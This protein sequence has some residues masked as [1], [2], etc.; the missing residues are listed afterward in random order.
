MQITALFD[1]LKEIRVKSGFLI[2]EVVNV[3]LI[4]S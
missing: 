2:F 1:N 3:K 4:H